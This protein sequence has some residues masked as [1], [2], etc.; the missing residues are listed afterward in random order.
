VKGTARVKIFNE[1]EWALHL[2]QRGKDIKAVEASANGR[3]SHM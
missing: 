1:S 2:P 3:T